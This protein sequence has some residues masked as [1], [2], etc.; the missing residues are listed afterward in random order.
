MLT[1]IVMLGCGSEG[2]PEK[3]AARC[4]DE[5]VRSP[6]QYTEGVPPPDGFYTGSM[7]FVIRLFAVFGCRYSVVTIL[8]WYAVVVIRL[9]LG[10]LL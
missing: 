2:L 9:S 8:L 6:G 5:N 7:I 10:I 4:E 1:A 3:Q